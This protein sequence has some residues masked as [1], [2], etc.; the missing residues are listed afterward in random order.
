MPTV[1]QV[2]V[3]GKR[4]LKVEVF[5][6]DIMLFTFSQERLIGEMYII[7]GDYLL[8]NF[9]KSPFALGMIAQ[10]K[11]KDFSKAYS[12]FPQND[13]PLPAQLPALPCSAPYTSQSHSHLRCQDKP[14]VL[15]HYRIL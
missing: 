10:I 13:L 14:L 3:K 4:E 9:M 1:S 6:L 11:E 15:L 5:M 12:H 2:V 8:P 7:L